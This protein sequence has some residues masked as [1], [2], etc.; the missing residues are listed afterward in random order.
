MHERTSSPPPD[1]AGLYRSELASANERVRKLE[2]ELHL[3]GGPRKAPPRPLTYV[4]VGV[5]ASLVAMSGVGVFAFRAVKHTTTS[6]DVPLP[7]LPVKPV[8]AAPSLGGAQWY[9]PWRSP[10]R[11]PILMDVNGDGQKDLVGLAWDPRNDEHALHAVAFDGR[12]F[13]MLWHSEGISTQWMSAQTGIRRDGDRLVVTDSRNELRLI[14]ARTGKVKELTLT[15]DP[16]YP[17]DDEPQRAEHEDLKRATPTSKKKGFYASEAHPS[18]EM[19]A[20]IGWADGGAD[21]VEWLVGWNKKT[22]AIAYEV[23]LLRETDARAPRS[24][25]TRAV[26]DVRVYTAFVSA[27]ATQARIVARSLA[28]GEVAWTTDLPGTDLGAQFRS[29]RAEDGQVFLGV[30]GTLVVLDAA[31]GREMSRLTDF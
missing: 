27:D 30:D 23:P 6:E 1:E 18:G 3:R 12:T 20:T 17:N 9:T 19:V 24:S 28:T 21:Q 11:T 16:R 2:E 26:D 10:D 29:L 8:A 15:P 4:L 5:V 22:K 7:P 13:R 31:L 25:R 14:D